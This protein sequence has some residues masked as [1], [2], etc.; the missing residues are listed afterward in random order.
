VVLIAATTRDLVRGLFDYHKI[1]RVPLEG[2]S[3]PV[4]AWQ[5]V[6][7]SAA[8]RF[9]A[10]REGNLTPLVGSIFCSG[11][12]SRSNRAKAASC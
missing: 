9:E 5:V 11:A 2:S 8:S 1:E 7:T 6:G 3:E 10:L 12:G 4:P